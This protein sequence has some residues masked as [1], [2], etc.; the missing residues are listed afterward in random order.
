MACGIILSG[1]L[2]RRFQVRGEPW[3]DKALYR[4]GN[5]PMIRLVY[6]AI[7]QVTGKVIIAVNNA[8]RAINYKSVLPSAEYVFDDGR[9]RGPLAGMYSALSACDEDYAIIVPNDMPYITPEALKRLMSGLRDFDVTT[10]IYK[11]ALGECLDGRQERHGASVHGPT[12]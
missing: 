12:H 3:V 5:E 7:S 2:S 8:E 11:W 6:N 1:G 9:L 4:I 10:Y